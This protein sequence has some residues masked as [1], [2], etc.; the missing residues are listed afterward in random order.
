MIDTSEEAVIFGPYDNSIDV[1]L[2]SW[3]SLK[4]ATDDGIS[5]FACILKVNAQLSKDMEKCTK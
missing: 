1:F 5:Q 4:D 3:N 2:K